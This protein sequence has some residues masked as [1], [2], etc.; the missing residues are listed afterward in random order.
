MKKKICDA[1]ACGSDIN[2]CKKDVKETIIDGCG[3]PITYCS[4]YE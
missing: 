2:N 3:R 4:K 1:C